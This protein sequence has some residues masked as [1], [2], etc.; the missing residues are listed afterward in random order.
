MNLQMI[1]AERLVNARQRGMLAA[2]F[3]AALSDADR[4]AALVEW[5]RRRSGLAWLAAEDSELWLAMVSDADLLP[6]IAPHAVG[7][8]AARD[9][10]F[11]NSATSAAVASH[12]GAMSVVAGSADAMVD[13][14]S[15]GTALAA[16][17]AVPAA[18]DALMS[19]AALAKAS[20]P[21]MTSNTAPSGVA[22]AK[23]SH[24]AEYEAWKAFDGADATFW[25]SAGAAAGEW[26]QY[27]FPA[28]VFGHS[29]TVSQ[30]GSGFSPKD[31][32]LQKS[33]DGV[34]FSDA[35]AMTLPA[36]GIAS[37]DVASAGFC[38]YWRLSISNNY[39]AGYAALRELS[40]TGFVKP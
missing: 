21:N 2:D 24:T 7:I 34:I 4:K 14:L 27:R 16:M 13:A 15:S 25:N 17:L 39:G 20:I 38:K 36:T 29:M 31:C 19:S 30:Y 35:K 12:S 23:T 9:I 18:K 40:F 3:V 10:I 1:R 22:S 8:K 28:D 32:I 6:L 26:I 11:A 5:L 33:V 37:I